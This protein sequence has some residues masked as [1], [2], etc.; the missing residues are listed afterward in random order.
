MPFACAERVRKS[1]SQ[2]SW[3]LV[4]GASTEHLRASAKRE[5]PSVDLVGVSGGA[6]LWL[7]KCHFQ[8]DDL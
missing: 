6:K 2:L 8:D 5:R 3:E 1:T 4:V 7:L